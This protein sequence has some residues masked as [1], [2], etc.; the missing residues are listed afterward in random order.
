M[1][2]VI[3]L[4]FIKLLVFVTS[5]AKLSFIMLNAAMLSVVAPKNNVAKSR[6]G[7]EGECTSNHCQVIEYVTSWGRDDKR[8]LGGN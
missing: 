7:G 6:E 1:P 8:Y 3:M 2:S 5:D 4:S